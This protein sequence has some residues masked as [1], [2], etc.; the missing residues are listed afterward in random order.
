MIVARHA[1]WAEKVF[2]L[3]VTGLFQRHFHAMRLLGEPPRAEPNLPLLLLPNHSTW[4]DGFFIHL[5]NKKIFLRRPYV[6]MLEEQLVRY[7]FFTRVGVFSI[8]PKSP[9]S[10]RASLRYAANVLRDPQ[11]LLAIFPQGELRPWDKR[12]L[13]YKRGLEVIL[14]LHTGPVNLLPLA[15]RAEFLG[16]QK[17]SVFFMFGENLPVDYS[18]FA[19]MAWLEKREEEALEKLRAMIVSGERGTKLL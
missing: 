8:D 6:M 12:P 17:P 7:P 11:N 14:K 10:M 5:L 16:E 15:I 4:W 19:G 9:A 18:S 3:Y 13:G 1:A 2:H